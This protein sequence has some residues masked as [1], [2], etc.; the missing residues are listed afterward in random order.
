VVQGR[1]VTEKRKKWKNRLDSRWFYFHILDRDTQAKART[2]S[3]WM[4]WPG[5][6]NGELECE[7]GKHEGKRELQARKKRGTEIPEKENH[8]VT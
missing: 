7:L 3:G 1:G 2:V 8:Q 5:K 4:I 6:G